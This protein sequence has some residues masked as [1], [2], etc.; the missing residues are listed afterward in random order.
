MPRGQR[1]FGKQRERLL[2]DL[3]LRLRLARKAEREAQ[4]AVNEENARRFHLFCDLPQ[5]R[6]G[7]G[8]D[9]DGLNGALDQS[10]GLMAGGS[11]RGEKNG[12][13]VALLEERGHGG[14]ALFD[15]P[16]WSCDGA[17]EAVVDRGE[18]AD[19]AGGLH[20]AETIEGQGEVLILLDAAMIEGITLVRDA[21]GREIGVHGNLAVAPIAPTDGFVKGRLGGQEEGGGGHHGD[22]GF[23]ERLPEDSARAPIHLPVGICP[24]KEAVAELQVVKRCH[25]FIVAQRTIEG[26]DFGVTDGFVMPALQSVIENEQLPLPN[27]AVIT[28]LVCAD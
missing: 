4:G 13:H 14:G 22:G 11:N 16:S 15:E 5:E 12:V 6:D 28:I 1:L 20:L 21:K 7:N 19:L 25:G 3:A 9:A 18:C 27:K 24:H 10:D 26:T 17:H 23:G 8:R 2:Q